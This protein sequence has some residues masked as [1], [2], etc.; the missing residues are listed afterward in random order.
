MLLHSTAGSNPSSVMA[1]RIRTAVAMCGDTSTTASLVGAQAS[2]QLSPGSDM[3]RPGSP[4]VVVVVEVEPVH[5][6]VVVVVVL[7]VV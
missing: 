4:T 7:V 3:T 5:V 1:A 2:V 6:V